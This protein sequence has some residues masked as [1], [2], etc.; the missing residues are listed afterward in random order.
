M[1]FFQV[2]S[3]ASKSDG[4]NSKPESLESFAAFFFGR[5]SEIHQEDALCDITVT[6]EGEKIK[7]HYPTKSR[8]WV[9]LTLSPFHQYLPVTT[10]PAR[11]LLENSPQKPI[12]LENSE[13]VRIV[14]MNGA[15]I[16]CSSR[17]FQ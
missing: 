15:V 12:A 8:Y 3:M 16:K 1:L 6:V 11:H 2:F 10:D 17:A 13:N 4:S 14:K 5:M 9:R 7:V